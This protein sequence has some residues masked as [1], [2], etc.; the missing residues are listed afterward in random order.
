MRI[1]GDREQTALA[2][3]RDQRADVE[4]RRR[5]D[6]AAFEHDDP[7]GLLDDVQTARL[8]RRR[9]RVDRRIDLRNAHE[10]QPCAAPR[11]SRAEKRC[12]GQYE[13]SEET[14]HR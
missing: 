1:E 5:P 8:T 2:P 7:S 4:E 10:V 13:E 6:V 14:S 9:G 11:A 3:A 12:C